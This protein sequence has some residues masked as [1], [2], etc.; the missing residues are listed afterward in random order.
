MTTT[1]LPVSAPIPSLARWGLTSDADLVFRTLA[2]FGAR[3]AR[4]LATE[5]GLARQRVES[6]LAELHE[7]G[8]AA[9]AAG[10]GRAMSWHS[11]PADEVV[12]LLRM[13]RMRPSDG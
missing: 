12:H 13:R 8:A 4:T 11:R 1:V 5:L 2:T 10:G 9:A 6:A 3:Q 7:C